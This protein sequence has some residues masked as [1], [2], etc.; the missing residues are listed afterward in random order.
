MAE[1]DVA[2]QFEAKIQGDATDL[3]A[4]LDYVACQELAEMLRMILHTSE[5]G[6][7]IWTIGNG[8]SAA[9][10]AHI[11]E[12]LGLVGVEAISLAS[13]AARLTALAN[14][15]GYENVFSNQL[16][17]LGKPGDMLLAFSVS[18]NSANI[19][20][21][22]KSAPDGVKKAAMLGMDG[23]VARRYVSHAVVVPSSDFGLV[24]S[25]HA[26]LCH[27]LTGAVA[28]QRK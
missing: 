27:I 13:D 28:K 24:E 17:V 19:V 21:A 14:D 25:A 5:E 18:G 1:P 3:K 8:G 12:D 10:A 23:G 11:A 15:F 16:E 4:M 22:L 9:N 26:L 2:R 20:Q 6:G 7:V